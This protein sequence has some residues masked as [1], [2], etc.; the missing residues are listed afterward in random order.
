MFVAGTYQR[1]QQNNYIAVIK[2]VCGSEMIT[3]APVWFWA[4]ELNGLKVI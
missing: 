2:R 3:M 4:C 1:P